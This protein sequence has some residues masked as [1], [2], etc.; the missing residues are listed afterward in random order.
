MVHHC[1]PETINGG[2]YATPLQD[3]IKVG[4]C[5][6]LTKGVCLLQD[7]APVHNAHVTKMKA[8]SCSYE[9]LP[10]PPY[11]PDL[12]PYDLHLFP[13]MNSFLEGKH[14]SEDDELTSDGMTEKDID[15]STRNTKPELVA[16]IK[17]VFPGTQCGMHSPGFACF[18]EAL[19]E[20]ESAYF[21][22][23]VISQP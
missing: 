14:F 23:A 1:D 20:V 21:G 7:N 11:F 8:H 15:R 16:K 9:I 18:L 2:Y 19:V 6:M 17:E 5:G 12:T 10:H 3:A 22:E 4:R 13:T